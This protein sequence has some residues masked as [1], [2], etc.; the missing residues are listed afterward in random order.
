MQHST[1]CDFCAYHA[2]L[3]VRRKFAEFSGAAFSILHVLQPRA[4]SQRKR[5]HATTPNL[6]LANQC[7]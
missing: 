4:S 1:T 6:S 3:F 5:H 2:T 7:F